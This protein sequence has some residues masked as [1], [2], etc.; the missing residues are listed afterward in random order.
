[1]EIMKGAWILE[2]PE[3]GP[4][5]S[6]DPEKVK[7]FM[8]ATHDKGRL[9]YRRDPATIGRQCV[10][11]GT[12][13]EGQ[14]LT[15]RTGNRRIWPIETDGQIID[16]DRLTD[17]LDQIWAEAVAI[18]RE[19]RQEK[20]AGD[21][22]LSIKGVDARRQALA[23]QRSRMIHTPENDWRDLI[24]DALNEG[25]AEGTVETTIGRW[26]AKTANGQTTHMPA[27]VDLKFVWC[28]ILEE[29]EEGWT[30]PEKGRNQAALA[31]V[32]SSIPGIRRGRKREGLV[33]QGFTAS[34]A[35]VSTYDI[36]YGR[37]PE[38]AE[39]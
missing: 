33:G 34:G 26:D 7:A 14:Y 1:M 8:S 27:Y 39:L 3:M 35:R 15:D 28:M 30:G 18:Y 10:F 21:L 16:T 32:M 24:I 17:N 12:S 11:G 2:I 13:N 37:L 23:A 5:K 38:P 6:V 31:S 19:M 20:P 29:L 9:A 36:D 4:H 25:V 22:D